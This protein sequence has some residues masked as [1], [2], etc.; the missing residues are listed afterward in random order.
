MQKEAHAKIAEV[1]ATL[2][3]ERRAAEADASREATEAEAW[4]GEQ[5]RLAERLDALRLS[6]HAYNKAKT[7][8]E[9]WEAQD[10]ASVPTC[11]DITYTLSVNPKSMF[12]NMWST[13]R[14][15]K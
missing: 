1:K 15:Q 10:E 5:R 9:F 8:L 7:E 13:Y 2:E 14:Q 4:A 3:R 11:T 6:E 12:G